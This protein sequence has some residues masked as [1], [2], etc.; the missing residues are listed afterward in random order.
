MLKTFLKSIA[1]SEKRNVI[2]HSDNQIEV[3]KTITQ[4]ESML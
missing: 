2:F 4:Y 3:C 1:K